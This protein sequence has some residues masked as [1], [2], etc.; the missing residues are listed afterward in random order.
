[1]YI[2]SFIILSC[3][4]AQLHPRNYA[5]AH[6]ANLG[7]LLIEFFELYGRNLN[8]SNVGISVSGHGRYFNKVRLWVFLSC[9]KA[10]GPVW[11]LWSVA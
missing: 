10:E 11:L 8:Y 6:D 4:V 1:M 7:V 2:F 5:S 3:C 9:V